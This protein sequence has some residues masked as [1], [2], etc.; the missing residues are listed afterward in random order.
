M[1]QQQGNISLGKGAIK[2]LDQFIKMVFIHTKN[3]V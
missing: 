1:K 3:T 2:I